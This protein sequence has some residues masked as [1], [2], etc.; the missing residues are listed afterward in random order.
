MIQLTLKEINKRESNRLRQKKYRESHKEK[1]KEYVKKNKERVNKY[2]KEWYYKNKEKVQQRSRELYIINRDKILAKTKEIR[3]LKKVSKSPKIIIEKQ[4]ILKYIKIE[5]GNCLKCSRLIIKKYPRKYCNECS[6]IVYYQKLKAYKK[7]ERFKIWNRKY[8][9]I[10]KARRRTQI[11]E[12]YKKWVHKS[13]TNRLGAYMRSYIAGAIRRDAKRQNKIKYGSMRDLL[14]CDIPTLKTH[15]E[16]TFTEGMTWEKVLSG[17]IHTDHIIPVSSFDL[18]KP[19]EQRKAFHYT[20]LQAL[21][22]EDNLKKNNTISEEWGNLN[23]K[24]QVEQ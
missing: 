2:S 11:R 12:S 24:I 6:K 13:I 15:L 7:T 1:I 19:E 9:K 21:W 22:K 18:S 23:H 20:N 8:S 10:Q 3:Q 14:G 17:E 5:Y 16:S 4:Y